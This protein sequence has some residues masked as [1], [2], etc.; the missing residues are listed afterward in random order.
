MK[1][2]FTILLL[3]FTVCAYSQNS[4]KTISYIGT[5]DTEDQKRDIVTYVTEKKDTL[6]I[7]DDGL[8]KLIKQVWDDKKFD[9]QRPVIIMTADIYAVVD[10]YKKRSTTSLKKVAKSKL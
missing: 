9:G 8:G 10:L 3:A 7:K 2:L 1:T 5:T 4:V 6:Y